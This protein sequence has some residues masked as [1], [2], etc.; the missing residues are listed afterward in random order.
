VSPVNA[1]HSFMSN[2]MWHTPGCFWVCSKGRK[3]SGEGYHRRRP[4]WGKQ[5][6]LAAQITGIKEGDS[7]GAWTIG[8]GHIAH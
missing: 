4:K 1:Q 3:V 2:E 5:G 8:C 6:I 7:S